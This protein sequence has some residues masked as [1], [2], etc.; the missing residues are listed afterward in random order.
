[1]IELKS[2][3]CCDNMNYFITTPQEEHE[4]IRYHSEKREY[5]LLLH[6]YDYGLEQ[7][8]YYCPWCGSKLPKSLGDEWCEVIKQ[9][10]G[11]EEVFAE[12][13]EKL[14]EEYKTDAWWKKRG[15]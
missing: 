12:E 6:G 5:R 14:P 9:K 2:E 10:F 3:Y 13:W 4:L 1:M 11:L 15:L 8:M 7:E